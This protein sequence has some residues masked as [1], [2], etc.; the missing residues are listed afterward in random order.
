[1]LF[2]NFGNLAEVSL[3]SI[4]DTNVHVHVYAREVSSFEG[5]PL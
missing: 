3:I 2:A 5:C 1:M 4:G